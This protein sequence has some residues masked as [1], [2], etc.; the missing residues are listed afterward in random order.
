MDSIVADQ[1]SH[2]FPGRIAISDISFR[3]SKGKITGLLGPNGAG[4][5]TTMRI[6]SGCLIP[7]EGNVFYESSRIDL[8]RTEIQSKLGYLPESAPLYEDLTV[9]EFLDFLARVRSVSSEIISK[10]VR[11]V[12]ELCELLEVFRV[13]IKFLSKGFKQRVA[14]AGT[15]VH[16]P[17]VL[18]L[19]EPSSGLDPHQIS[20]I[21]SLIR[22]LGKEKILLLS[23]HILQEV[24]E[25]CDQ[26]IILHKGRIVADLKVQ[27]LRRQQPITLVADT[28]LKTVQES[29]SDLNCLVEEV[30]FGS[31]KEFRIL[32]ENLSP[33]SIFE[34]I[35][36]AKFAVKE[37]RREKKSLESLFKELTA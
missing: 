18:I 19:D 29:L 27:D 17:E 31:E 30:G 25:L 33:E 4:K 1:L 2:S 11:E 14:L 21:R 13:P 8:H 24:E 15:L 12:L 35:R 16:D 36:S 9:S 37:F 23:T 6:L 20:S 34:K 26:V 32:S 22:N 10:R 28:D 3:I 7:Q 5:T